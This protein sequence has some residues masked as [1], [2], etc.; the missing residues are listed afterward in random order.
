[1][2]KTYD[3]FRQ[4]DLQKQI[5][6]RKLQKTCETML[7]KKE[8][9][10]C[11][12]MCTTIASIGGQ[13][14][15]MKYPMVVGDMGNLQTE[16]QRLIEL[17]K[18]VEEDY[19]QCEGA[20]TMLMEFKESLDPLNKQVG[21]TFTQWKNA[22]RKL[23]M[24]KE[25]MED[26]GDEIMDNT[27]IALEWDQKLKGTGEEL[28]KAQ[29]ALKS[30]QDENAQLTELFQSTLATS[31][32]V[33]RTLLEFM[34]AL[35]AAEEIKAKIILVLSQLKFFYQMFVNEFISNAG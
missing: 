9:E 31:E 25:E 7:P 21:F 11:E 5:D 22:K 18:K 17:G 26:L 34:N 28:E 15:Q 16:L 2:D 3:A 30:L 1:M 33:K 12:Q 32:E 13:L 4:T 23:A 10:Y 8:E 14:S 19:H 27:E 29:K 35:K 20:H 6:P 24:A